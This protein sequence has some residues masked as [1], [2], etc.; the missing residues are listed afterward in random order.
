MT[1]EAQVLGHL[2]TLQYLM[3]M[4]LA[5]LLLQPIKMNRPPP[6]PLRPAFLFCSKTSI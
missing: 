3:L 5:D 4:R 2:L 6:L 1:M